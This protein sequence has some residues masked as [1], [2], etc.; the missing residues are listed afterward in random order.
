[1]ELTEDQRRAIAWAKE[2]DAAEAEV[3]LRRYAPLGGGK[4]RE[5]PRKAQVMRE[6][7]DGIGYDVYHP[8]RGWRHVSAVRVAAQLQM[9]RLLAGTGLVKPPRD[10]RR[11]LY[12]ADVAPVP[13]GHETRQQRRHAARKAADR[14]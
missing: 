8:T 13:Q 5:K 7:E 3:D 12:R 4:H 9:Q 14:G 10:R 6:H 11:K 2:M 1:M